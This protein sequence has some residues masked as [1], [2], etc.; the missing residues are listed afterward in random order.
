M[1]VGVVLFLTVQVDNEATPP[2]WVGGCSPDRHL[3]SGGSRNA[4]DLL[5]TALD[6]VSMHRKLLRRSGHGKPSKLEMEG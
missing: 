5:A 1:R 3:E 6:L 4:E 2:R